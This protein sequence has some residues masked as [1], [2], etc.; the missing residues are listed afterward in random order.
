MKTIK[1]GET[2]LVET[3]TAVD[4]LTIEDGSSVAAPE[5]KCAIMTVNGALTDLLPGSYEG[6]IVISVVDKVDSWCGF[7]NNYRSAVMFG[8]DGLNK[9]VSV[10]PA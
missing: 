10:L 7:E 8:K 2:W 9:S 3:T 6:S 5:G 1:K 4:G